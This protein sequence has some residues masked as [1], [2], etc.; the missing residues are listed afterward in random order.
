MLYAHAVLVTSQ[1]A[2][3]AHIK[4]P[5]FPVVLTFN[6][7]VDQGRST[8]TL[9]DAKQGRVALAIQRNA[10]GPEKLLSTASHVMPGSYLLHWQVLSIDGHITQGQISFEVQ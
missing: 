7:R 9:E 6:S 3:H 2:L 8:L 5:S 10:G 4:G 1:P